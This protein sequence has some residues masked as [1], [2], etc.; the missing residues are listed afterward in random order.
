[1]TSVNSQCSPLSPTIESGHAG[2]G[3]IE[4]S[5]TGAQGEDKDKTDEFLADAEVRTAR[6]ARQP[7]APTKYEIEQHLPLHAEYRDWCPHCVAGKGI[8]HQHRTHSGDEPLGNTVS[9]DYA[10]MTKED[11]SDQMCPV[12]L[13]YDHQKWDI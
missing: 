11:E 3:G 12:L 9:C 2:A 10:F 5:Q 13:A 8:S 4:T 1:M 6:V 7:N